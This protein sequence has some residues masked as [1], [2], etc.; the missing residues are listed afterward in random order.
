MLRSATAYVFVLTSVARL[1][2]RA[3]QYRVRALLQNSGQAPRIRVNGFTVIVIFVETKWKRNEGHSGLNQKWASIRF[4]VP[5]RSDFVFN[6]N[7]FSP[8]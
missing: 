3:L 1:K 7:A 2:F 4:D 5:F 8:C 6:T